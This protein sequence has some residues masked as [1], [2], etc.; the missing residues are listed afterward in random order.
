MRHNVPSRSGRSGSS[1]G[2]LG[3]SSS[4][5]LLL[6]LSSWWVD[7]A[8]WGEGGFGVVTSSPRAA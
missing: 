7:A 2:G 6:S 3:D 5:E 8:R 1:A 4:E